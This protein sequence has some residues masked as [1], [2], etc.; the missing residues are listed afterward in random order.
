[1]HKNRIAEHRAERRYSAGVRPIQF[2]DC[3]DKA[4]VNHFNREETCHE[5]ECFIMAY[6]DGELDEDGR[7]AIEAF[8][9]QNPKAREIADEMRSVTM[10]LREA[11]LEPIDCSPSR[12]QRP[13]PAETG[14]P[15]AVPNRSRGRI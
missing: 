10:L 6:V 14:V 5:D 4:D 12:Q 3:K 8:L 2:R 1:M 13:K 7:R 11:F 9:E 15:D